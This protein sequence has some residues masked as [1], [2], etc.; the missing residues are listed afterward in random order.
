MDM[1]LSIRVLR[2]TRTVC[3]LYLRTSSNATSNRRTAE[4][5]PPR[6]QWL[7]LAV[8]KAKK[9]PP[10]RG[11]FY[12]E[13]PARRYTWRY[14]CLNVKNYWRVRQL[15]L[16]KRGRCKTSK[17]IVGAVYDRAYFVNFRKIAR[18]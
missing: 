17:S 8:M 18:P 3:V 7:R 9:A 15:P 4:I 1:A 12:Y 14:A 11:H 2:S 5:I 13:Q 16:L 6:N 10:R